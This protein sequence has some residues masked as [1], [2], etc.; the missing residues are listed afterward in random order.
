MLSFAEGPAPLAIDADVETGA[1]PLVFGA[2]EGMIPRIEEIRSAFTQIRVDSRN[3]RLGEQ[4][5]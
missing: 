3:K 4:G 2:A 5:S 1:D